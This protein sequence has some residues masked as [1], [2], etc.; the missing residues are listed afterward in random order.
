MPPPVDLIRTI[1]DYSYYHTH[2]RFVSPYDDF[3]EPENWLLPF[4]YVDSSRDIWEHRRLALEQKVPRVERLLKSA[5][6]GEEETRLLMAD[7]ERGPKLWAV[8]SVAGAWKRILEESGVVCQPILNGEKVSFKGLQDPNLV[9]QKI[10]QRY[11]AYREEGKKSEVRLSK[12]RFSGRDPF[13][14]LALEVLAE[15]AEAAWVV[16]KDL[17]KKRKLAKEPI[18]GQ[19]II[20]LKPGEVRIVAGGND[21]GKTT[22]ERALVAYAAAMRNFR[23]R[24]LAQLAE[25]PPIGY[26]GVAAPETRGDLFG[27]GLEVELKDI[28]RVL[29]QAAAFQ[30]PLFVFGDLLQ[31]TN[32]ETAVAASLALTEHILKIWPEAIVLA[33]T[34]NAAALFEAHQQFSDLPLTFEQIDSGHKVTS[35]APERIYENVGAVVQRGIEEGEAADLSEKRGRRY[36]RTDERTMDF[37]FGADENWLKFLISGVATGELDETAAAYFYEWLSAGDLEK[38]RELGRLATPALL[39]R[40]LD[41][42][43]RRKEDVVAAITAVNKAAQGVSETHPLHEFG[44][45]LASF[46]VSKKENLEEKEKAVAGV[47][48]AGFALFLEKKTF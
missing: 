6:L 20:D 47:G 13:S 14:Q 4:Y 10:W 37:I 15:V 33:D 28:A 24:V 45:S 11:I 25:L 7:K 35:F 2:K 8:A 36:K 22:R 5:G 9:W 12:V 16:G 17:L 23:A 41:S 32:E 30:M 3:V 34:H 1:R 29:E 19:D 46:L 39:S 18:V 44:R 42:E 48:L 27:S 43:T 31:T 26:L 21:A 38:W 40:V